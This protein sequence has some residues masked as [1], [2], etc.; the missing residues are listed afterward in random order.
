MSRKRQWEQQLGN[1]S[2]HGADVEVAKIMADQFDIGKK[3]EVD[4]NSLPVTLGVVG[5]R[6]IPIDP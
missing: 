3:T 5:R 6:R 2:L 4:G 1:R